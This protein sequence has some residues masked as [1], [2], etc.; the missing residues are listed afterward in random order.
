MRNPFRRRRNQGTHAVVALPRDYRSL[1]DEEQREFIR[2]LLQGL[3]TAN[4]GAGAARAK[5]HREALERRQANEG[6]VSEPN[7]GA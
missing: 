1:S 4:P 7:G 5:V 3:G 6:G 2:E